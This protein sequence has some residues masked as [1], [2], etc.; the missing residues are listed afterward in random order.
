MCDKKLNTSGLPVTSAASL[1]STGRVKAGPPLFLDPAAVE[2]TA[3]PLSA[4][5]ADKEEEFRACPEQLYFLFSASFLDGITHFLGRKNHYRRHFAECI[6][7][8]YLLADRGC[9]CSAPA[10]FPPAQ[11]GC[12]PGL[13]GLEWEE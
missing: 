7:G 12:S 5:P 10:E 3:Q 1:P 6:P 11:W 4:G 13:R 2:T 8:Y 9:S